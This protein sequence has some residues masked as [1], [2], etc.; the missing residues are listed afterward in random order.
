MCTLWRHRDSCL[1]QGHVGGSDNWWHRDSWGT[2]IHGMRKS[3]QG[4]EYLR[5]MSY[6]TEKLRD[7][8]NWLIG[9]GPD[10]QKRYNVMA[11]CST[12]MFQLQDLC[13]P[14]KKHQTFLTHLCEKH[15]SPR[16]HGC[17]LQHPLWVLHLVSRAPQHF[18]FSPLS[19]CSKWQTFSRASWVGTLP[20]VLNHW[21]QPAWLLL[22]A[23]FCLVLS[24]LAF[25]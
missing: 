6:N 24:A 7:S 14:P 1:Q 19:N 13:M 11:L 22:N 2:L 20:V 5:G 15:P 18:I 10:P 21:A 25:H 16:D 12:P 4:Q 9:S 8:G 3:A 17:L 23:H